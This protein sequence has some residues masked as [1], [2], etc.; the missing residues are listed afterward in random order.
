VQVAIDP[1]FAGPG[2]RALESGEADIPAL[3]RFFEE[4]PEYFLVTSGEGPHAGQGREEFEALPPPDF[5]H[6][7]KWVIRFVDAQGAMIALAIVMSNLPAPG[8]WHLALFIV[9]TGLH[10]KGE[11]KSLHDA[12]EGW[13]RG[14]GAQWLRLGVVVGNTRAE[15]FWERLGYVEA[16]RREGVPAGRRVNTVRTMLKPLG[17]EDL[18]GYLAR[19]PRD[20]PESPQERHVRRT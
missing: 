2:F 5:A 1:L 18:A 12:L 13:M 7:R 15:R 8:V 9:A 16:R 10:G 3:Q 14:S 6:D 19:V 17:G 4:N 11:A 20:R